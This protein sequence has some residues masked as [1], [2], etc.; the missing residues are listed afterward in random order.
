MDSLEMQAVACRNTLSRLH[1]VSMSR[2]MPK[3]EGATGLVI[4]LRQ[5]GRCRQ[6]NE[7]SWWNARNASTVDG[8]WHKAPTLFYV[9]N[10]SLLPLRY[11]AVLGERADFSSERRFV[12]A[13]VRRPQET[14]RRK[15]YLL[16]CGITCALA[17]LALSV[18]HL[19]S[20]CGET[21]LV[22]CR[23]DPRRAGGM[24]LPVRSSE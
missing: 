12:V 23:H 3:R 2:R 13:G 7:C 15:R 1:C 24:H 21:C 10:W 4:G 22:A 14:W 8:F 18:A 16:R 5:G 9:L 17:S 6:R 19:I 20:P 11:L